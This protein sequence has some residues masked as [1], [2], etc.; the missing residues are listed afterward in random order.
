MA[1]QLC[2]TLWELWHQN[3]GAYLSLCHTVETVCAKMKV[4]IQQY[5]KCRL[6]PE[7]WVQASKTYLRRVW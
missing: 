2:S 4:L 6:P 3:T 1:L 7:L 5:G